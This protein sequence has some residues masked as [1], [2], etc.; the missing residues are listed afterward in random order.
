MLY[1]VVIFLYGDNEI[2]NVSDTALSRWDPYIGHICPKSV[3][4]HVFKN[5]LILK[6][7]GI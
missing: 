4:I 7:Y 3:Y 2:N 6:R 5:C 1:F